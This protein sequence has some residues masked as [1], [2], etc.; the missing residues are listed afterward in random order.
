MLI[1]NNIVVIY[2]KKN[3]FKYATAQYY[4][5]KLTTINTLIEKII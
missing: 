3:S 4:C 2:Q 5:I 1:Y